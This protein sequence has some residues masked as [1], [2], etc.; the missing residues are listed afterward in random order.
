MT[1]LFLSS[2]FVDVS[3][4]L[5]PFLGEE[6]KNK[7]ITFIPTA[8]VPE[9]YKA[10]VTNDRK[11]FEKLGIIIEELDISN[12][13]T[14]QIEQVI[15]K[16]DFIYISGGNTFYL[17]QELKTSGADKIILK[18]IK[19]GKP[20]IGASAGSIIMSKNIEYVEKMDDKVKAKNLDDYNALNVVVFYTLPHHTNEPFKK[21]VEE[22]MVDYKDKIDLI[23]ISNTEV[24]Q[25]NGENI[26]IIGTK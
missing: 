11:A 16:N 22:I 5:E 19:K 7:R 23:P 6:L 15:K 9:E 21:S 1:K 26:K 20:Y 2:S 18:E 3:E 8:S 17:L 12:T 14:S 24:I 10:Y 25:V 4:F 13:G